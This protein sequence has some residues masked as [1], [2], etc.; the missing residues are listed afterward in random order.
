M[1]GNA[2]VQVGDVLPPAA[3][4]AC[5]RR[6]A[7]AK[8][9]SVER[10]PT[11]LC[12]HRARPKRGSDGAACAGAGT[13]DGLQL[14]PDRNRGPALKTPRRAASARMSAPLN[15]HRRVKDATPGCHD[16][17]PRPT[18]CC[19]PPTLCS[20]AFS[21]DCRPAGQHVAAGPH[22]L[23][24][25]PAGLDAG[26]LERAPATA[27]SAWARLSCLAW[28]WT[29]TRPPCWANTHWPTPVLSFLAIT[30]HRRLLWFR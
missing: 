29:C 11:P 5:T 25:R 3:S 2:D 23:D 6:P 8:V 4:M 19:C 13:R 22:C 30:I 26:V 21:A 24:A 9:A 15:T 18:N 7:V 17:A 14:P 1:A 10:V 27:Q 16:H 20:F 28:P 12:A